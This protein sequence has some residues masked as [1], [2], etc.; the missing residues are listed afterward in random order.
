MKRF[1]SVLLLTVAF[2]TMCLAAPFVEDSVLTAQGSKNGGTL[3]LALPSAPQS[4]N[5]YG[6]L[7]N[8]AYTV[9]NQF[10]AGLVDLHPV[11][12][13]VRPG[14]AE[15]WEFSKDYMEIT[16]KLRDVKWS[17]GV[18]FTAD[19]V[20]F[21]MDYFVM[22]KV[23][24]GN[25]VDR[26][27]A[28]GKQV[29]WVKINPK[30]VKAVLP[31]PMPGI[32]QSLAQA[33]IYPKH[34]LEAKIDKSNPDSVN[35][36][37]L[38]DTPTKGFTSIGPYMLS[39]YIVDQKV[40]LKKNPNYW[41][42]DSKNNKLPYFDSLEYL[43]VKDAEVRTAMFM[44]GQ[45]DWMDVEA[46]AYPT[47]KQKELSGAP[48]TIFL[49]EPTKN[50]PSPVHIAFNFDASNINLKNLFSNTKFRQAMEFALDRYRIIDEVYQGLAVL[51]GVPVLPS[52]KAFYNPKIESIRR[53]F[54]LSKA[55]TYL[56]ELGI[57]DTNKDGIR[58]FKD[59][60]KVEF[61]LLVA[62]SPVDHQ[63]VGL[64]FKENVEKLGIKINLQVLDA[65]LVGQ[66]FGSG[67]FEAGIRAFGNQPD[68]ELRKAI[69]QPGR[70][71]YYF[72]RTTMNQN[73]KEPDQTYMYDW[74]KEVFEMFE[75][76]AVTM[77]PEL[78]KSYYDKWQELYAEYLPVIF[79][80]KGKNLYGANKTLGNAY[81]AKDGLV[82]F[83]TWTA[84][85][86]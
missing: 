41:K 78:R 51:G 24:K 74:E 40:V 80:C 23:A 8:S 68:P 71:L 84:Y 21:T 42:V 1:L 3:R 14:L 67:D 50:V 4:F 25:S 27:T 73:T 33:N 65:T 13:V 60:T 70:Q 15:S 30:T 57:K 37:W 46:T 36:V 18:P 66:K 61:T 34:K 38:T 47:L 20:L 31:A 16:F 12:N 7:D 6:V 64:V 69:W 35:K 86:K 2:F 81:Q 43:I 63:D 49:A 17:D 44:S 77:N 5:F 26:F 54:D 53:G 83:S 10:L 82:Y 56:D 22:N 76:G 59:G 29:E 85:R 32:F 75:K 72:H 52:N 9:I 45:L 11:T 62:N 19:D 79:V 55:A 58:E 28:A 39:D 48:F